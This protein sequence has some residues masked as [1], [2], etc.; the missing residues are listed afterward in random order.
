MEDTIPY[1]KLYAEH[2]RV[3]AEYYKDTE[4]FH[5]Q[6]QEYKTALLNLGYFVGIRLEE[7][8]SPHLSEQKIKQGIAEKFYKG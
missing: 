2:Q 1:E 8:I 3:L 4:D 6:I 7:D 5:Q